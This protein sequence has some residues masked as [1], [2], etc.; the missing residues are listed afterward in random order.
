MTKSQ[1][2]LMLAL[3]AGVF[4]ILL[5]IS[6]GAGTAGPAKAKSITEA[7]VAGDPREA[8]V[9]NAEQHQFALEQMRGL[10]VTIRD[11]DAAETIP[12]QAKAIELARAQGPGSGSKHPDGF[13][14]ALPEG[15]RQMSQAM[16][17]SFA[18]MADAAAKGDKP[19]YQKSQQQALNTVSIR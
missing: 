17:K 3:L 8:V 12:D 13:H 19:A 1:S 4:G 14:E 15:F 5:Y 10:L 6:F 16:R 7:Q 2:N 11:L 9:L 18:A